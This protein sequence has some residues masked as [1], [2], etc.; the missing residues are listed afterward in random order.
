MYSTTL[1]LTAILSVALV[2]MFLGFAFASL[3]GRG[4]SRWRDAEKAIT[5]RYFSTRLLWP[6]WRR[7]S[8]PHPTTA[9]VVTATSPAQAQPQ[10]EVAAAATPPTAIADKPAAAPPLFPVAAAAPSS[11]NPS[12]RLVLKPKDEPEEICRESVE[13]SLQR[14]LTAWM[15]NEQRLETPSL[16]GISVIIRDPS[17]DPEVARSV[18]NSV[19]TKIAAQLRKD[20]RILCPQENQLVWFA[21]DTN[22][23]DGLMPLSR[24][25]QLLEKTRF[26]RG[27]TSL[28]VETATALMSVSANDTPA[29]ALKRMQQTLAYA[30]EKGAGSV[31]VE[32]GNG[33]ALVEPVPMDVDAS[34]CIVG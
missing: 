17:A 33:P 23:D 24:I 4:P 25:R 29:I 15:A 3:M 16:C 28:T 19:A 21:A 2:N 30:Q 18:M 7:K 9:T 31:C 14:Q 5:I 6:Q 1:A 8:E 13:E 26:L 32:L 11:L 10:K 12:P 34:E 22:P 27:D 20:R